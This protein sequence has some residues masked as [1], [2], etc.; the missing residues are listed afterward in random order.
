MGDVFRKRTEDYV[1]KSVYAPALRCRA[2]AVRVIAA[3][4][5]KKGV[6]LENSYPELYMPLKD[7]I[8]SEKSNVLRELIQRLL[9]GER[10]FL[11]DEVVDDE[12][13]IETDE[14]NNYW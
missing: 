8:L 9:N 10:E 11:E 5:T 7:A 14:V 13:D 1:R 6:P 2:H 12:Y 4:V 3:W